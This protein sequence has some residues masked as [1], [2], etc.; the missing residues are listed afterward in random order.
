MGETSHTTSALILVQSN[1]NA[2][3]RAG[4]RNSVGRPDVR[5]KTSALRLGVLIDSETLSGILTYWGL[6][7]LRRC[8]RKTKKLVS[9][10][11]DLPGVRRA[12]ET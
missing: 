11:Q 6:M 4:N 12:G 10:S 5:S 2:K 9:A 1:E 7:S 3:M 8:S